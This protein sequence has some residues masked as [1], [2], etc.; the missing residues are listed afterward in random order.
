MADH[1]ELFAVLRHFSAVMIDDY[2]VSDVLA[3]LASSTTRIFDASAG[4]VSVG[5]GERLQ[6]IT[7]TDETATSVER[8]QEAFQ[9]GP[10]VE[11]FTTGQVVTVQRMSNAGRWPEYRAAATSAGYAS[12][13]GVPLVVGEHRIGSLN[14]YDTTE[15]SWSDTDLEAA[16]VLADVATAYLVRS[17]QLG[18]ARRLAGQLQV[19]LEGRVVIE[20][21]KGQLAERHGLEVD[22]AF[23]LLRRHARSRN[24]KLRD[25]AQEVV[26]G[27][28]ELPG[29][30]PSVG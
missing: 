24:V 12:A 17:G 9:A 3:D 2:D 30:P 28:L 27:R 19:A 8:V 15:R 20:Q 23:D 16:R 25:L 4:G 1:T 21:A 6:F 13:V 14:V 18:E 11:A 10:C 26:E 22:Q 29:D 7:A 5:V